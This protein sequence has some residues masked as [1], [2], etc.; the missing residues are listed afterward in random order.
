MSRYVIFGLVFSVACGPAYSVAEPVQDTVGGD[1]A[2]ELAQ[3]QTDAGAAV[4][5]SDSGSE[6]SGQ[7]EGRGGGARDGSETAEATSPTDAGGAVPE[8]AA[9]DAQVCAGYACVVTAPKACVSSWNNTLSFTTDGTTCQVTV[10]GYE[11]C[12]G[13]M[14]CQTQ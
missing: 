7:A 12:V 11:G 4:Y 9:I 1:D 2:A 6:D 5:P 10:S 3:V 8:G 13:T 14:V